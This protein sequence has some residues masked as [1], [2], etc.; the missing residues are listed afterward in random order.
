MGHT[1]LSERALVGDILHRDITT[2]H[3]KVYYVR[4]FILCVCVCVYRK[5]I[6]NI[7]HQAPH[8]DC[9]LPGSCTI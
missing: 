7:S 6:K 1:D 9:C 2:N 5:A 4:M 3:T 8:E